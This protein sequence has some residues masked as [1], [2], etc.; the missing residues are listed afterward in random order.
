MMKTI[1]YASFNEQL[2][3]EKLEN[4]LTVYLQPKKGF[5]KS[6][7]ILGVNYGSVD[8]DFSINGTP[9]SQPAGIAHFIEHKMFDKKDY[10]V[11]ELFNK[12][13]A[14]ANA[15]TSF[16]KTNYLFSTTEDLRDNLLILL[17]FV[18]KPYFTTEKIEREKGI[19][20]QEINMYLNDPDNRIYFQTIQDLY[21]QSPLSE[22]IAGTVDSVSKI[23]LA[24]VQ[25]A[26]ETFY[27]PDNMS[28]FITGRVNPEETLS[29]IKENQRQKSWS[30]PAVIERN[31]VFPTVA[32]DKIN[33]YQMAISRP[34]ASIGIRGNDSVP[35]GREGLAY[36][37]AIS[38]VLDLFFSETAEDYTQLYQDGVLDDSF[39]WEFE[40][41]RGFHFAI[42]N[43]DTNKPQ[44]FI[45]KLLKIIRQIP[46]KLSG[47]SSEFE[48]QKKEL[49]GN[50]IEMMDSEEAIS[51]Q[52]DGFLS[53]P[54]TIY[55]EVGILD[56]LTLEQTVAFAEQYFDSA[57]IQSEIIQ[58]N[59]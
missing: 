42:L 49:L 17:D 29:W 30:V 34:K 11:F 33:K 27:R 41:E 22:D 40:N 25:R 28:L 2:F 43:G 52:F 58:A 15:Y 59:D 35:R 50:Y 45:D 10:D 55:D 13:G 20:D 6:I 56:S 21:P 51:G 26:Y 24:D 38:L 14:S 47:M 57:S 54:L 1:D 32:N 23:T 7:A 9:V 8:T 19:I 31:L 16:T 48:L 12:T 46:K 39:S 3:V 18:Q 37:I 5:E 53:E 36:E 44:D 4:G